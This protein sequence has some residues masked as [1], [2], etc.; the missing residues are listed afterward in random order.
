[1]REL[2]RLQRE[3]Y[4]KMMRLKLL[5]RKRPEKNRE[6]EDFL[7]EM[8]VEWFDQQDEAV[9]LRKPQQLNAFPLEILITAVII[10]IIF[11]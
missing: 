1:M 10:H 2:K 9:G 4:E 5:N 6:N 7:V 3:K 8:P 11:I